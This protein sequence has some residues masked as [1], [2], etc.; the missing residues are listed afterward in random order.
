[1]ARRL[2]REVLRPENPEVLSAIGGALSL[3]RAEV[4]RA[5]RGP[6]GDAEARRQELAREAELECVQAGAAPASVTVETRYESDE[7]VMR[8]VATGAVALEAGAASREPAA[9]DQ[10]LRAAAEVLAIAEREL[11][12]IA[13]NDFYRVFS[14][15]G[16]GRVAIVDSMG[17]VAWSELKARTVFAGS[18]RDFL[19]RLADAV[20]GAS[21][22]LGIGS[23]VPRVTLLHGTTLSDLSDAREPGEVCRSAERLLSEHDGEAVAI[24]AR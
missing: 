8:A 12:L 16:S 23:L 3:I 4:C 15:N 9:A 21:V 5:P 18:G 10:Q 20:D 7:G 17:G 24:V 11:D 13:E 19:E 6:N 1:V 14:E 2:G 22:N